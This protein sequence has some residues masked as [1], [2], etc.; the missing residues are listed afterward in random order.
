MK[1]VIKGGVP[2]HKPYLGECWE[3]T[4][5]FSKS[6]YGRL[7]GILA[8]RISYELFVKEIPDE[9]CVCH[10]CDNKKC[11]RPEHL[12]AG[13]HK[14]NSADMT[15]K[16]RAGFQNPSIAKIISEKISRSN[17]GKKQTEE[18]KQKRNAQLKNRKPTKKR[19][20]IH[21]DGR[22]EVITNL[23]EFCRKNNLN[24]NSLL[25]RLNVVD[26]YRDYKFRK[27]E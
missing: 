12:F 22:E 18:T 8:H 13:S 7:G 19:I 23:S 2:E 21:P 24:Y 16:S 9:W 14:D 1:R 10:H 15:S 27:V 25:K 4:G 17:K 6:G 11:I 3:W 20:V 26:Y 5:S